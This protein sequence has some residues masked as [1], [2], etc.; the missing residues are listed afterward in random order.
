MLTFLH[1]HQTFELLTGRWLF[2]P[3]EGDTWTLDDDHL[4]KMRE[5]TGD[6]FTPQMLDFSLDAEQFFDEEGQCPH[7]I[8]PTPSVAYAHSRVVGN[9]L[10]VPELIPVPLEQAISVYNAVPGDEVDSIADFIRACLRL[11]PL[12]RP[13]ARE[14][15]DHP[16]LAKAF[17]C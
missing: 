9:L 13:S 12:Q 16:W 7:A 2:H 15:E 5:L 3:E 1:F 11:D 4:A 8:F 17:S 10:R 14:L 6:E